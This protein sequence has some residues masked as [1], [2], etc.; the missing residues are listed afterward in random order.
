M[1]LVSPAVLRDSS[2]S[3]AGLE[4]GGEEEQNAAR[5]GPSPACPGARWSAAL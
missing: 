3:D 1:S 5:P 2:A 4:V